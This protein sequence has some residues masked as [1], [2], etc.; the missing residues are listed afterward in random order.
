MPKATE[1]AIQKSDCQRADLVDIFPGLR[2]NIPKSII[3]KPIIIIPKT[4]KS[5]A[6]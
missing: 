2:C 6:S 4:K 1:I 5:Q 3:R